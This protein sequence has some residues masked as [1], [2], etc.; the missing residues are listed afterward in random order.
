MGLMWMAEDFVQLYLHYNALGSTP[1]AHQLE[2]ATKLR[3]IAE[4]D[5]LTYDNVRRIFNPFFN[6]DKPRNE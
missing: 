5:F 4:F 3:G 6:E 1:P 2:I